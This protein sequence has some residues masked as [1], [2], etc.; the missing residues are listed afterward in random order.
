MHRCNTSPIHHAL[1]A[2]AHEIDMIGTEEKAEQGIYFPIPAPKLTTGF[3]AKP[4]GLFSM[5]LARR[6]A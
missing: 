1:S 3:R 4:N 6:A 2:P 5:E